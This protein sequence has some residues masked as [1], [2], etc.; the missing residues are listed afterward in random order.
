MYAC[1]IDIHNEHRGMAPW[2]RMM[3]VVM[4][5]LEFDKH[6]CGLFNEQSRWAPQLLH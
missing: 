5:S 4:K 3:V 6:E 2:Q 1:L